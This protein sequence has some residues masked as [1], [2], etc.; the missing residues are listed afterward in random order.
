M[1]IDKLYDFLCS[2]YNLPAGLHPSDFLLT[3]PPHLEP[4]ANDRWGREAVFAIKKGNNW[5]VGIYIKPEIM[6]RLE[7]NKFSI[8]ELSCAIEGVSHFVYLIDRIKHN[9]HCSLLELELQAEVDKFITLSA[10]GKFKSAHT[11]KSFKA[12]F[13][14]FK[15]SKHLNSDEK[16]RY[17]L[18]N[19][20]AAKYCDKLKRE[21][22][23]DHMNNMK[24]NANLFYRKDLKGKI[25]I[26]A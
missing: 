19:K 5:D 20:F 23:T 13:N 24:N 15:F 21:I 16:T 2:F 4:T 12:L 14:L 10:C 1:I 7:E 25:S 26:L 22:I 3:K 6:K 9:K 11:I 17:F 18:A 8:D